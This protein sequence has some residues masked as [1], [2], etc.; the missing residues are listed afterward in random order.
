MV[1]AEEVADVSEAY[2]VSAVP[3]FLFF[4]SGKLV[5]RLSGAHA[6]ELS[7][8]VSRGARPTSASPLPNGPSQD[9]AS[10]PMSLRDRLDKLV[11]SC[12]TLLFMKGTR[13]EPRC[14]FSSKVVTA[15]QKEGADFQTFDILSDQ[16]VRQGMKEYSD[17]PTFPQ[18]YHEGE[19]VGGCDI[20]LEMSK[21]GELAELL[22]PKTASNGVAH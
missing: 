19:F 5:D 10:P 11:K 4:E 18:L 20:V 9:V 14:G 22:Q 12:R 16:D 1:E 3:Y 7:A 13:D 6:P 21:S 17:W 15:L 2:D 8:K